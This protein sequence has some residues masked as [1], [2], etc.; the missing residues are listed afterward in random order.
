MEE[1]KFRRNKMIYVFIFINFEYC[2]IV[3]LGIEIYLECFGKGI[4]L[5]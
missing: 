5:V 1:S 4:I 3:D 2:E